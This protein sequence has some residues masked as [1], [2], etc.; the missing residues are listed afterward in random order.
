MT[1]DS[2]VRILSVNRRASF[3]YEILEIFEAGIQLRGSEVKS[4]RAGKINLRDCFV[5]ARN[6]ELF[7]INMNIS[8]YDNASTHEVLDPRRE[9]KLL[10]HK[11]EIV[12]LASK[13]QEKGLTIIPLKVYL[14]NGRIKIEIALAKGRRAYDKRQVLKKRTMEKEIREAVKRWR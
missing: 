13:V 5:R 8:T 12:K 7:I 4:A 11:K 9:R 1:R 3:D 10:M 6:G 2:N 14:K